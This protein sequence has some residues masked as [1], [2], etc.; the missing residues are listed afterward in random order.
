MS[1]KKHN[2]W[3]NYQTWRVNLEILSDLEFNVEV[4]A[5][6][7]K[8]V[9]EYEVFDPHPDMG[10]MESFARSFIAEVNFYEIASGIN[11]QIKE[12]R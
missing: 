3:T 7:L 5:D 8:A 10:L 4:T 6:D 1:D 9:V 12:N 11:E 2:G